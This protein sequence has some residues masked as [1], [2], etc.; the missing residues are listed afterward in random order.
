MRRI[1]RTIGTTLSAL[2]LAGSAQI[3]GSLAAPGDNAVV[4]WNEFALK[5]IGADSATSAASAA[6]LYAAIT[7][8]AVY[9]AVMAIEGTHEPYAFSGEVAPGASVDAAVAA[10]AHDVLV[11]YFNSPSQLS[12]IDA[13][14]S[15]SLAQITDGPSEDDG[16]VVGQAAAAAIIALRANDGR[17]APVPAP[18]DGTQPGQWRR[19]KAGSVVTPYTAQVTPFLANSPEQFRPKGPQK[20]A[21]KRYAEE[22]ER[23]RQYGGKQDTALTDVIRSPEQDEVAAF[24][25]ENTVRQYNRALGGLALERGLSTGDTAVLFAMTTIPAADAMITCWNT[26]FHYLAWRPVTAIHE[27]NNDGNP[28][29][30]ADPDWQPLSDTAL[31]PEYTSGHACLTGAITRGLQEFFGT[32]KIDLTITF[33][34]SSGDIV[35]THIFQTV[36]D[37]RR[38]VEDARV[39]GGDHWTTGGIDGTKL[40]DE[41]AKWAL[42]RNFEE[43]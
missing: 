42:K 24:W 14:Y 3:Q 21:S 20:L 18:A 38:E 13:A 32:K 5:T 37:L 4:H 11:E 10:A 1:A 34:N 33:V 9:D 15:D 16:V 8:A 17:D 41:V 23:T 12:T 43:V 36:N 22:F 7:Q 31:H 35:Y 27:A 29:T 28:R 6:I 30:T 2:M 25:T 40:G 39:Y 19:T 26:K